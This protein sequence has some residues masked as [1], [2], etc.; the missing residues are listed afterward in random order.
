MKPDF[1]GYPSQMEEEY[2]EDEFNYDEKKTLLVINNDLEVYQ[3]KIDFKE[4][5]KTVTVKALT[6]MYSNSTAIS[7][8]NI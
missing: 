7:I 1:R 5:I 8:D 2:T 3:D 4:T 6:S